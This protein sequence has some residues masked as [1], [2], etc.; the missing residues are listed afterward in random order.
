MQDV[1]GNIYIKNNEARKT[2]QCD[3]AN[4]GTNEIDVSS[5]PPRRAM[6]IETSEALRTGRHMQDQPSM[7]KKVYPDRNTLSYPLKCENLIR[8]KLP[9]NVALPEARRTLRAPFS[10]AILSSVASHRPCRAE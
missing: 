2:S 7:T 9:K 8:S 5:S 10:C 1:K 6:R 3:V 4:I